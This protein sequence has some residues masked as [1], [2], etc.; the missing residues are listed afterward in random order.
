MNKQVFLKEIEANAG[1]GFTVAMV[2][3]LPLVLPLGAVLMD[4]QRA[5]IENAAALLAMGRERTAAAILG[6]VERDHGVT[7]ELHIAGVLSAAAVLGDE[8]AH[9]VRRKSHE[10]REQAAVDR[11]TLLMTPIRVRP[12]TDAAQLSMASAEVAR[13]DAVTATK[14]KDHNAARAALTKARINELRAASAQ[15]IVLDAVWIEG[16][17]A[18]T[19]ALRSANGDHVAPARAFTDDDEIGMAARFSL[20]DGLEVLGDAA[21]LTLNQV[22]TGCAYRT[23]REDAPDKLR[24]QMAGEGGSGSGSDPDQLKRVRRALRRARG[25]LAL[26]RIEFEVGRLGLRELRVLRWVAGCG[27]SINA[28][29]SSGGARRANTDA[30]KRA[31]DRAA[32]VMWNSEDLRIGGN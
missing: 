10:A 4:V 25:A 3:S 27:G 2:G 12:L 20:R 1:G 7:Q 26:T 6:H 5:A 21:T 19:V 22:R 8:G 15:R 9:A 29:G 28:L 31:L 32:V 14:A 24:S 23:M 17:E 30:L 18:E 13:G 11:A 16:A